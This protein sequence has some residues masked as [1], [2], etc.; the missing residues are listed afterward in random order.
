M[1][2]DRVI[3]QARAVAALRGA[4]AA[5]RVA[6][7]YL[8]HGPDG[9]G[10]RAAA[11]A[12]AQALECER[13][14][15]G[16][17][18][19]CG[20][21]GPCQKVARLIHPDVHVYFPQ[22]SDAEPSDVAA[23]LA[24][25]AEDPYAE[26]GFRRRPSLDDP[27]KTST[28]QVIYPVGRMREEVGRDLRFTPA[29]GRYKVALLTDADAMNVEASNA[30]LKTLEEPTPRTVLILTASRPDRLLPTITSRCQRLRF[31]ALAVE[32]IERALTERAG[33]DPVRA[34]LLARMADGSYT[35]ALTLAGSEELA[36]RRDQVLHF[37]RYA[38]S[39]KVGPLD[40]LISTLAGRGREPLKAT[41]VLMLVWVRDLVLARALG[42]EAPIVNV[43]QAGAVH[44]FVAGVPEADL[45]AIAGLVEHAVE[46]VERNAN[47]ALVLTVLADA[48][49]Q[50]MLGRSRGRLFAPLA[51]V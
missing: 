21:C 40:D 6:H 15:D 2:W 48:L 9:V 45:D 44:R 16:S 28:K 12:L 24:R 20:A 22:P 23:R 17:G 38:Y 10:K 32:E 29:E 31:D 26:V 39:D 1:P 30:F 34:G 36:E 4:V 33:L 50:A 11:L 19:A 46:L 37:F 49:R 13:R 8:F 41:L 43:D 25:L 35:Q 14:P 27:A 5:G 42:A 7:A 3:G 51:E 47:A 18:D